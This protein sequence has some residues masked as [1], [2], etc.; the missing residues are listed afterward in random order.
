MQAPAKQGV[1]KKRSC[2]ADK[3][4]C[5]RT[6]E[7]EDASLHKEAC[8]LMPLRNGPAKKQRP[9]E[10]PRALPLRP[11]WEALSECQAGFMLQCAPAPA[12]KG[13]GFRST[14]RRKKGNNANRN[15]GGKN[16]GDRND[17]RQEHVANN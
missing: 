12:S 13:G 2:N 5:M 16:G 7:G 10:E 9:V 11:A 14:P 4:M 17:G 6:S 1:A 15:K 8:T 3:P